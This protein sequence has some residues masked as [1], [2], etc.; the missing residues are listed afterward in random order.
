M[1]R[2]LIIPLQFYNQ[3]LGD[4][5]ISRRKFSKI[6][7]IFFTKGMQKI[8]V[9]GEWLL[10]YLPPKPKVVDKMLESFKKNEKNVRKERCFVPTN[11]CP[12]LL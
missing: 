6:K 8:K 7:K 10:N 9:F 3:H 1:S 12:N 4:H 2:F 11:N 5:Q